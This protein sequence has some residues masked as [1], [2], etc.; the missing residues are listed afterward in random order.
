MEQSP[1]SAVLRLRPLACLAR[2]H[3]LGDVDV[4]THPEGEPANQRP[5]LGPPEMPPQRSVVALAQHLRPQVAACGDAQPVRRPL[6]PSVQQ[7]APHQERTA[8][9]DPGGVKDSVA[10]PVDGL[11]QRRRR[12]PHDG[13]EE[14]VHCQ[15]PHQGL[16]ERRCEEV[17]VRRDRRCWRR[18]RPRAQVQLRPC[19]RHK[20]TGTRGGYAPPP[21]PHGGDGVPPLNVGESGCGHPAVRRPPSAKNGQHR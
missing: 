14:R 4:L 3:V 21:G 1:R 11:A 8:G 7:A 6:T 13:S 5:R 16:H 20:H 10:V 9:R 12:P 17:G 18:R 19:K 2:A 15:L